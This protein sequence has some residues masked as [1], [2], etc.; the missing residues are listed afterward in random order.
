MSLDVL[1]PWTVDFIKISIEDWQTKKEK[2]L[3][4]PDW[5]EDSLWLN[6]HFTDFAYNYQAAP[7]T[8][9]F[10]EILKP[11]LIPLVHHFAGHFEVLSLWCQR[12]EKSQYMPAHSHGAS[13]YSAILYAEFNEE[14]HESTT[15]IAP[16]KKFADGD[17]L[18]WKPEVSE[19]DLIVFPSCLLHHA[20]PNKSDTQRTIF[21][22]NMKML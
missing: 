8:Q 22:F 11:D 1:K 15:F 13:G 12:Y 2:I 10:L 5:G 19:G 14:A 18:S 3:G 4:L 20:Q 17:D 16:F 21:S 7:Y 9:E 6:D